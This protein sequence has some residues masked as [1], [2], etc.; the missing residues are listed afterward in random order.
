MPRG[1]ARPGAGRKPKP[2][3]P[4]EAPAKLRVRAPKA[5]APKGEKAPDA[6]SGWPFGTGG[7]AADS[8]SSPGQAPEVPAADPTLMPLDYL[9]QVVRNPLADDKLRI[10]CAAIAAPF[11]HAKKGEAAGKKIERQGAAD[12]A[13][14]GKFKPATPPKLVVNN[15]K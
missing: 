15:R 1:G 8:A 9:L 3:A 10:Q 12:A 13:A 6:P 14:G 5:F 2:R 4:D 7:Q 11:C